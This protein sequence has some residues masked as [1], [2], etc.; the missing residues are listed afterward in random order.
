M[1][2]LL[3]F[4]LLS[5]VISSATGC[6]KEKCP[7]PPEPTMEDYLTMDAWNYNSKLTQRDGQDASSND[8][9]GWQRVFTPSGDNYLYNQYGNTVYYGIY[10]F[11][12]DADPMTISMY[13]QGSVT[14]VIYIVAKLTKDSL[15]Y[16]N[17]EQLGGHRY[18][19][20]YFYTRLQD[21]EN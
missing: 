3:R 16:F 10:E 17:E 19:Y 8:Y 14:P 4:I 15:V 12:S 7:A 9:D 11:N 5:L 20:T 21:E 13:S 1:K 6:K 18:R 2:H